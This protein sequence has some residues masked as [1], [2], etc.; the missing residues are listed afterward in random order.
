MVRDWVEEKEAAA[1]KER[2]TVPAGWDVPLATRKEAA[3]MIRIRAR[4]TK[5]VGAEETVCW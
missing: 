2:I 1:T 5:N 3:P 4:Y